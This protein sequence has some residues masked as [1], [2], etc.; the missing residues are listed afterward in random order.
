MYS[1]LYFYT[2][3]LPKPASLTS[4]YSYF[5]LC[6]FTLH[7]SAFIIS[8]FSL[9]HSPYIL[10]HHC[11]IFFLTFIHLSSLLSF[12]YILFLLLIFFPLLKFPSCNINLSFVCVYVCVRAH[13]F[14]FPC[15][16]FVF[17][18]IC[19]F[20]LVC[21]HALVCTHACIHFPPSHVLCF[22]PF[23]M[24]FSPFCLMCGCAF[25]SLPQPLSSSP[26]QQQET[27]RAGEGDPPYT[28]PGGHLALTPTSPCLCHSPQ[29]WPQY[30]LTCPVASCIIL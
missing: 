5:N 19:T 20:M 22:L 11:S 3:T 24:H 18:I 12:L 10:C 15:L 26:L 27:Q 2:S 25:S 21:V 8:C 6:I 14:L 4:L 9:S 16:L 30:C 23:Y 17:V 1:L 28:R 13:V 7:P 29:G